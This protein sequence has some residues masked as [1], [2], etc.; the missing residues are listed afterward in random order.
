[1]RACTRRTGTCKPSSSRWKS[2][3]PAGLALA[4]HLGRTVTACSRGG[5][6]RA[7]RRAS[8]R[9][10]ATQSAQTLLASTGVVLSRL[11]EEV[12]HVLDH[13]H[14]RTADEDP[15]L[16]VRTRD[17]GRCDVRAADVGCDGVARQHLQVR[18]RSVVSQGRQRVVRGVAVP[19]DRRSSSLRAALACVDRVGSR[20]S[21]LRP[22]RS[23]RRARRRGRTCPRHR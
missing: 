12:E 3:T 11:A 22:V 14:R 23:P 13:R 20:T 10:R 1:M 9:S 4:V 17:P 19:P 8:P 21:N 7:S 5:Q 16:K 18:P 2:A 6:Y 15:E